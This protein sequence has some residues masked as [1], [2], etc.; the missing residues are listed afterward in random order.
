M[1]LLSSFDIFSIFPI[2]ILHFIFIFHFL[3]SSLTSTKFLFHHL[4]ILSVLLRRLLMPTNYLWSASTFEQ[5]DDKIM[6]F[7][8]INQCLTHFRCKEK[9]LRS[10]ELIFK[11][12]N[13]E[14]SFGIN[15]LSREART[16]NK[17]QKFS[18]WKR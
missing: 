16:T 5:I 2:S 4:Y 14:Y 13:Q 6:D 12:K 8:N 18:I 17:M 3:F 10:K 15:W 1:H 7:M 11:V 9:K